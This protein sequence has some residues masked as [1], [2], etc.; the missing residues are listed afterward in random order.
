[1]GH[2]LEHL[3][4]ASAAALLAL[5]ADELPEG[6]RVSAVVPDMRAIFAAYDAARSPTSLNDRYVYS[7]EQPSHH[8]WCHD[9]GSLRRRLRARRLPRRA[10][11]RPAHV[12]AGVLEGRSRIALA[13]RGAGTVPAVGRH[14][15][16]RIR[17][18]A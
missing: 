16:R 6:A 11:D 7:Y 12:G 10:A 18:A 9:A 14:C 17:A 5:V 1:M 15:G 2:F 4:P 13:E 8:V 3:M